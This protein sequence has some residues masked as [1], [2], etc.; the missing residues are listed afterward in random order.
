M[1]SLVSPSKAFERPNLSI[2]HVQWIAF[3]ST[4]RC[5]NFHNP[6]LYICRVL[7]TCS[8]MGQ[9]FELDQNSFLKLEM[10]CFEL[11]K[12]KNLISCDQ[13]SVGSFVSK[14]WKEN[15]LVMILKHECYTQCLSKVHR[16][17]KKH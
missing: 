16:G 8:K 14:N 9:Y 17:M 3:F 12:L 15:C 4:N 11:Y 1:L 10:F 2:V 6:R 13:R 5:H 7:F